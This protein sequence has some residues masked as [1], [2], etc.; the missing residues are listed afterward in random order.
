MENK[1]KKYSYEYIAETKLATKT[2]RDKLVTKT[3]LTSSLR[4]V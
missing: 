3:T 1:N 4:H 2:T